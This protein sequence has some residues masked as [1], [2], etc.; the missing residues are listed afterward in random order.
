MRLYIVR[1]KNKFNGYYVLSKHKPFDMLRRLK[2][3]LPWVRECTV[4]ELTDPAD[5][6]EVIN[7]EYNY[8]RV[9]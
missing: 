1:T 9:I 5:I 7:S 4:A 6:E 2:E 8:I 3:R